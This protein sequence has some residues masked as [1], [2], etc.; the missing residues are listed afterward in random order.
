MVKGQLNYVT[1][2]QLAELEADLKDQKESRRKWQNKAG[3][4]NDKLEDL[5]CVINSTVP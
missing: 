5:V 2:V 3:E 1:N 4:L